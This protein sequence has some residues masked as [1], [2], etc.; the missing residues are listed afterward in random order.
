MCFP[1]VKYE[2]NVKMTSV[3]DGKFLNSL[4]DGKAGKSAFPSETEKRLI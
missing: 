4:D 3:K 1:N 2:K